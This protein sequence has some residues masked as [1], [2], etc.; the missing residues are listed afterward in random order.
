MPS[1]EQITAAVKQKLDES[2]KALDELKAKMDSAGGEASEELSEA[3]DSAEGVLAKGRA[4]LKEM[5]E[6]SDEK[7]DEMWAGTK[8][9]WHEVSADI[10]RQ[11]DHLSDRVKRFFR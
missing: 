8:E 7:F 4:R 3:V 10:E 6:A 11:W 5:S 2:R 9:S 1:R